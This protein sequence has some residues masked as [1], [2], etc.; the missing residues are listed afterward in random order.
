MKPGNDGLNSR[1]VES[2]IEVGSMRLDLDAF[3]YMDP[4]P[5][6]HQL[7]K[8][9]CWQVTVEGA[10]PGL[11]TPVFLSPDVIESVMCPTTKYNVTAIHQEDAS[12]LPEKENSSSRKRKTAPSIME[13]LE[14]SKSFLPGD[15]NELEK[16]SSRR[17]RESRPAAPQLG[18]EPE[19]EAQWRFS[20]CR[21]LVPPE[22][23]VDQNQKDFTESH[24]FLMQ[25]CLRS[26]DVPIVPEK[27]SSKKWRKKGFF[28]IK[29]FPKSKKSSLAAGPHS[30]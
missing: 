6:S 11:E 29:L 15:M 3:D 13:F 18:D 23:Q 28:S 14:V 22:F 4:Q 5:T 8:K 10:F 27:E 2:A 1:F 17:F 20:S 12:D 19:Y 24:C 7:G 16:K 26:E 30:C 25:I 21:F 9:G